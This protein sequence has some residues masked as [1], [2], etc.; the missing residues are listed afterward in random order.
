MRLI[1]DI[2][3][4][5]HN[6]FWN[7]ATIAENSY[8]C[9]YC[10]RHTSSVEG[11]SFK[12]K[13][14]GTTSIYQSGNDGVYICTHC[15]MPTFSWVDIQIPGNRF[16]NPISGVSDIVSGVY[17][18]A[19][20]SFSVGAYTAVVLLC[21]KLLMNLAVDLGAT[22]NK[23]FLFYV[24]YLKDNH[25]IPVNSGEWV[26]TIRQHGN[27]ATHETELKTK[28]DAENMIKFSEMLIKMNYEYPSQIARV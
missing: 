20:A 17:E 9:G 14:K 16:G 18:E 12:R 6:Y 23:N 2:S 4:N 15:R 3:S 22:E 25:Y 11:L 1:K 5:T 26:D 27:E 13:A 24:N 7:G 10:G 28:N 19:R 8:T 21:R